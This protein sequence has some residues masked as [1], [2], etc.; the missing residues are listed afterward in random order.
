MTSFHL[1]DGRKLFVIVMFVLFGLA[2]GSFSPNPVLAQGTLPFTENFSTFTGAGFAPTPAAG[3]LD[4]DTWRLTGFSD[5]SMTFGSTNTSGDFARGTSTGGVTT[6][7]VYAFNVG[8]GNIIL[9]IQPT[10]DDFTPGE[11]TLRI[12]NT[13]GTTI[14]ELNVSY[15]IFYRNDQARANSLNFR[16]SSDDITYTAIGALDF[17]T[18]AA[19]DALGWQSVSRSTTITGLSIPDGSFVYLQWIGDDVS[20]TGSRDEYGIDNINVSV[21][22]PPDTPPTVTSTIPANL[23]TG[24]LVNSNITINFSEAVD[25]SAGAV[26]LDCDTFTTTPAL[27][28]TNITSLVLDPTGDLPY[29]TTCNVVVIAANVVDRDGT[30]DNMTANY[31]FSFTTEAPPAVGTRIRDIQ[32]TGHVSPLLN[33]AVTNV[34]GIVTALLNNGF[35]MQDPDLSGDTTGD[36]SSEGIFVFTGSAP[37][38]AIG[39]AILVS[40][41]VRERFGQTQIGGTNAGT[42]PPNSTPVG[43]SPGSTAVTVATWSCT[44]TCTITPIIVGDGNSNAQLACGSTVSRQRPFTIIEDDNFTSFDITTDAMDFWESLEGMRVCMHNIR[45]I[46]PNRSF[47]EFWIV[48]DNG[49]GATPFNSRG[50]LTIDASDFNPETIHM[51]NTLFNGIGGQPPSSAYPT[52]V[53]VGA[54]IAG[55]VQGVIGYSF[56][57]YEFLPNQPFTLTPSTLTREVT[58]LVATTPSQFTI[59]TYNVENLGGNAPVSEFNERA[60]QICDHLRAPDV[61]MLQEIQDNN[62]ATNDGVVDSATTLTNLVN[63]INTTCGVTYN[64]AVI[65][66]VNNQDGGQPGGNIRVAYLYRPDRGVN[67]TTGSTGG[68]TDATTVTCVAGTPTFNYTLGR[69]D[70]TNA[71]FNSSRKPLF[72]QFSFNGIPMYLI[73]VHM[74]SKGGD[75]PLWGFTQP[76]VLSSE[77]QRIQQ[78]TVIQGFIQSILTCDPT[79]NIVIA[80]DYNDFQFSAPV[81]ILVSTTPALTVMNTTLPSQE[82][83]SY[84]FKGNSQALDHISVSANLFNNTSPVYDTVHINS[85]FFDQVS[86]HDPSLILITIPPYSLDE[87]ATA[88][89]TPLTSTNPAT[90]V[91]I[92]VTANVNT[93]TVTFTA[94]VKYGNPANPDHADNADNYILLAEGAITGFQTGGGTA[95]QNP[96]NAGDTE[97]IPTTVTYNNATRTTTLT[98]GSTL[99]IGKYSLIICGSTSIVDVFS[100]PL[101]NGQDVQYFFDIVDSTTTPVEPGNPNPTGS[102]TTLTRE[103]IIAT[104]TG[105]PATGETPAWADTA[106]TVI[107]IST[108]MVMMVIMLGGWVM[109]RRRQNR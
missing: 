2:L 70:P 25:V 89:T 56:D 23:A 81:S 86:D 20:G 62:G 68:S 51:D 103:E 5:G 52:S 22:T 46:G 80:G 59:A 34:P 12:Q 10:A 45:T 69:I 93:I 50:G 18:P 82:R 90:P 92:N 87:S 109:M 8:A 35:W 63:A 38:V 29:S 26:T 7:G 6:G 66:P 17:T 14:N 78:A 19:A 15:D 105:L 77:A 47:D 33:T 97:I 4:S 53:D 54:L 42:I 99:G 74:N 64:F 71:A 30:P 72:G 9:G 96:V 27:P 16:Y 98:L 32:G 58:S 102:G 85:E 40:G 79:A 84:N 101:N 57:D 43:G 106:R 75:N 83:Y 13:T 36:A 41:V 3:Q 49:V 21:S 60:T 11:I 1:N 91:L 31:A 104:V 73:N 61:V 95:C 28:A 100:R 37:T 24:V 48:P 55:A 65:N 67:L 108:V 107:I 44:G 88:Q 39:D 94:D 76:P